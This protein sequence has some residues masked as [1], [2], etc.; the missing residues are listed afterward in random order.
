MIYL[1]I[2]LGLGIVSAIIFLFIVYFDKPEGHLDWSDYLTAL[3]YIPL[4]PV[5]PLGFIVWEI[6]DL[7]DSYKYN[8]KYG[9][10][11]EKTPKS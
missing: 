7:I 11:K 6:E 1:Y 3:I 8:K 4:W 5:G 9:K 2:Y 10:R